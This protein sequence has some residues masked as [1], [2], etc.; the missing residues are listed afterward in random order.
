MEQVTCGKCRFCAKCE[1]NLL[2]CRFDPP[3]IVVVNNKPMPFWPTMRPEDWCGKGVAKTN[4][5]SGHVDVTNLDGIPKC[6]CGQ[7]FN[8][9][10]Q[11]EEHLK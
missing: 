1:N 6:S 9:Q 5:H 2:A 3:S 7:T 10:Q 4:L 11:F 8:T